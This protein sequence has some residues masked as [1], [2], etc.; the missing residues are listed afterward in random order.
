MK[1]IINTILDEIQWLA[2]KKIAH[3]IVHFRFHKK[4]MP[5]SNPRKYDE[6]IRWLLV[7]CYGKK[8]SRY[9]DKALVRDYI[10]E[11][12][13]ESLLVPCWGVWDSSK[14]I[15]ISKL[16][17]KF[18]LKT[19]NGSGEAC[20]EIVEDKSD[21]NKVKAALE[22][23]DKALMINVA[24]ISCEYHYRYIKPRII[25]EELLDSGEKRITDYKVICIG[26]QAKYILVCSERD[27]GRDYF[28]REWNDMKFTKPEYRYNGIIKKPK[29]LN[30]MLEAAEILSKPFVFA[31]VDFYDINGKVYFG[32][33]TLTPASG[34]TPNLTDEAQLIIGEQIKLPQKNK[35]GKNE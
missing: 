34:Y 7:N 10:K 28:D 14:E 20:Y 16:P 21:M 12:G 11:C 32:E 1:R 6:K 5:W 2:P 33:I 18:I 30:Y 22:K 24:K 17:Q 13:L 27:L 9:A 26:G 35:R 3:T 4:M 29:G 23:M 25:C 8:E 19:T 15:D 31:R